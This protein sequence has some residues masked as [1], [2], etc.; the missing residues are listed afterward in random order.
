MASLAILL[1]S[2]FVSTSLGEPPLCDYSCTPGGGCSVHYVGP[3]RGGQTQGSCFPES[4][5]GSCDGTPPE[6]ERCNQVVKDCHLKGDTSKEVRN[7][8]VEGD[9]PMG[10]ISSGEEGG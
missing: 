9:A 1:F 4:F 10:N 3:P 5:G 7:I 8:T 6:C 2:H